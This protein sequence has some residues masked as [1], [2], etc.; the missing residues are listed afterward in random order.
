MS[1]KRPFLFSAMLGLSALLLLFFLPPARQSALLLCNRL[2]ALSQSRNAYVY[3]FFSVPQDTSALPASALLFLC[4]PAL[5]LGAWRFR[6]AALLLAAALA[7]LQAVLGISLPVWANLLLFGALG[8]CLTRRRAVRILP[9]LFAVLLGSVLLFPGTNDAVEAA[10]ERVRDQLSLL[11]EETFDL[12]AE[13]TPE[14][15]E[16]RRENRLSLAEG[17]GQAQKNHAYRLQTQLEKQVSAPD[18]WNILRVVLIV[19]LILALLIVPF[20]PFLAGSKRR[21]AEEALRA[22][23]NS[24]DPREALCAMFPYIARLWLKAN[25]LPPGTSFSRLADELS[26]PEPYK[27]QYRACAAIWQ[28]VVYGQRTPSEEQR[29]QTARLLEETER[30]FSSK[31][32]A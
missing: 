25:T 16:T 5:I 19:L 12:S 30:I 14:A 31:R 32:K 23:M 8:F 6:P 10:S 22:R 24:D 2:F 29:A 17:G 18:L 21:K 15:L 26:M 4:L 11:A 20:L 13:S 7:V 9:I 3:D 1:N 28:G 27:A